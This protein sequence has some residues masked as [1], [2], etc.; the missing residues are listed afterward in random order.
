MAVLSG[1][2]V[3]VHQ[4]SNGGELA[5]PGSDNLILNLAGVLAVILQQLNCSLGYVYEIMGV[6]IGS[7]VAPLA[8][9]LM[10]K[11][12]NKW[13]AICGAFGGQWCGLISWVLFAKV[14]P[15][16]STINDLGRNSLHGLKCQTNQIL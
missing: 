9:C 10:W 6:L 4:D 3:K 14:S 7:G 5:L 2:V 1:T 11:K 8:M 12:T 13:G 16:Y 15:H